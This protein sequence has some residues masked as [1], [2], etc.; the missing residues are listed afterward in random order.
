MRSAAS[1]HLPRSIS[2]IAISAPLSTT[3][4]AFDIAVASVD[5]WS[6]SA[7]AWSTSPVSRCASAS[8]YTAVLSHGLSGGSWATAKL[9]SDIMCSGPALQNAAR[10]IARDESNEA[11]PSSGVRSN[12]RVS[13]I[14]AHRSAAAVCPVNRLSQPARTA[15]GG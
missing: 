12:E 1:V 13:S 4:S 7:A 11:E 8:R 9:A 5:A 14:A 3:M 6:N 10:N 15:S 2:K